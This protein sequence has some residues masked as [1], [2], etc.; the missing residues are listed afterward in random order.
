MGWL[1]S[2][3]LTPIYNEYILDFRCLIYA[4]FFQERN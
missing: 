2:V 3:Q 1:R 4:H